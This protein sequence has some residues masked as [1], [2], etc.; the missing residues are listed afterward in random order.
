MFLKIWRL[1]TLI[2][3]ALFM[4]L[5]FAHAL[6]LPPKM[7]YDGALYVTIQ[8]SLYGYFGAPGPGAFITVGAV[9]CVIALTILVRKH[10]VAFWWTLAGTLCLAIA[11]PLIYF[12]RIEPVNVV[13]E[14]ANAT[15]LPTN[16]QQLRNQWEYAHATN[17]IC[18]LA[19]F[20]ALL[21]SVLVDV[22][23]RTSK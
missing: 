21:I 17:F 1:I 7:Q 4:G 22:P 23:Q 16:W 12:L 10:R 11:F 2:I 9:L 20:S 19:G 6:E 18:S 8:N 13:I 14:Q 5:E 15:S 3:V